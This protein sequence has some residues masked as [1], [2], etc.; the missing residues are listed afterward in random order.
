MLLYQLTKKKKP[1]VTSIRIHY[2]HTYKNK[3]KRRLK[4]GCSHTLKYTLFLD[5]KDNPIFKIH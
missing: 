1:L 3:T 4:R 5:I 2:P